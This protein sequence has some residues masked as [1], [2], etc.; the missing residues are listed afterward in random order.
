MFIMLLACMAATPQMTSP[1]TRHDNPQQVAIDTIT[2]KAAPGLSSDNHFETARG[3]FDVQMEIANQ[4]A[5][6][7]LINQH[8]VEMNGRTGDL[9]PAI[10]SS[11]RG[12]RQ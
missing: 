10:I 9:Q 1:A 3:H 8:T 6:R 2:G 4:V 11:I 5:G 12:G 7:S